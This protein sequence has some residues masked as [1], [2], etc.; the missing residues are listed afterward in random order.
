MK[1]RTAFFT[2]ILLISPLLVLGINRD[3]DSEQENVTPVAQSVASNLDKAENFLSQGAVSQGVS[4]LLDVTLMVYPEQRMP[5]GF[6]DHI[7]T[8]KKAFI[9]QEFPAGCEHAAQALDLWKKG[10]ELSDDAE[11]TGTT[12]SKTP[13]PIAELFKNKLIESRQQ[14]KQGRADVGVA[15]ILEAI[16]FLS[17]RK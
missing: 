7:Q 12:E 9:S 11:G 5:A 15:K 1:Q 4:L 10:F 16:L 8:A 6:K 13:G 14:F 2:A 3:R 17:P